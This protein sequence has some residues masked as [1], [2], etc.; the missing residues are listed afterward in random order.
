MVISV[1]SFS[2]LQTMRI[3]W[4]VVLCFLFS[5]LGINQP[6]FAVVDYEGAVGELPPVELSRQIRSFFP[7]SDGISELLD[8]PRV[9][10]I[11]TKG[12][13]VGWAFVTSNI[14]DIPAYSGKPVVMLIGLDTLGGLVGVNVLEH[15]EPILLV[16]I[17]EQ[18]LFDFVDKYV[19]TNVSDRV[20]VGAQQKTQKNEHVISVDAITGATVTVMVVNEAIMRS[21]KKVAKALGLIESVRVEIAPATLNMDIVQL[22]T[23]QQ[24]TGD[25]SVRKL[26]L[27]RGDIDQVF[28]GTKAGKIGVALPGEERELFIDMFYTYINAPSIGRSL[29][30]ESEYTWLMGELKEGE[31]AIVVMGNG[32]YSFKGSGYVRGG[33]FDRIQ[34]V[35]SD[36]T[37]SFRDLDYFR[38]LDVYAEGIPAFS[39]KAIFIIRAQHGFLLG[40]PWQLELLVRRQIGPIESTF[41]S[42][43]AEYQ[44]PEI[45]VHR[46][47]PVVLE[48]EYLPVWVSI[49]QD[50]LFQIIV[51]LISLVLLLIIIFL[52]DWL[53][54]YPRFLHNLRRIYLIYTVTFIGWYTLG[55]LS[56]VNVFTFVH[57]FMGNFSWDLFLMDPML[58]I[59]WGFTA[60]TLILWG[61]GIFCGWLCPFGALQELINEVARKLKIK[62]FE[63]P[64]AIHE[65]LWAIK[66]MI[67][68][69]LFGISL[70][71]MTMAEKLAEVEPFKTSI[72]LMFQR[73]W[74]FVTY[75]VVLLVISIFT[76]KVYCRYIC[77]LGAALAIPTKL[78]L[79]DWLYRRKECGD[80]CQLCAVECEIQ[81]I[82]PD[83][84]INAN[85]CHHCLDCQMTYHN[86]NKCPP[87]VNKQK[88]RNR[89]RK[90]NE[91]AVE[92]V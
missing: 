37:L 61:R 52:Q 69:A 81:A 63:V 26:T 90:N 66:Y 62:Q 10:P 78:R 59:L 71:S 67:L 20:K 36:A 92:N 77:P 84:R 74:W 8:E 3:H 58:F 51:L 34:L 16:G 80:P 44:L 7:S 55:Q 54:R 83:G 18:A 49:W 21:T 70:E 88:K 13:V 15:H 91:I 47:E 43:N 27:T 89:K 42:F 1:L 50:K 73:E 23:W 33:I 35:Q 60:M 38:L 9:W 46:P 11:T 32:E 19:G 45:Y 82:H 75:A 79:F 24:L 57:A 53:V 87:L 41:A 72:T 64:F 30:G 6:L 76:R 14:V 39:E 28:L 12:D 86:N 22:Q 48:E 5:L 85:E 31:H 29:L 2:T 4:M 17:P 68:L 56:V 25:G 65:R 40:Q